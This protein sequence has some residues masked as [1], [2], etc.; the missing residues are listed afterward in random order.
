MLGSMSH[1]VK[2][3]LTSLDGGI[4]RLESGLKKGDGER[5]EAAARTLKSMIGR[6]RKMVLDILYYAKSRELETE[7]VDATRFLNDT[8]DVAAARAAAGKVEFV[9][10]I[11]D[12]LGTIRADTAA[13]SAALVNFLE[14]GVDACEG[15]KDGRLA[16][17]AKRTR[18]GLVITI[19]DNGSGMDRETR[20]KIFTLF[21]SSKGKR[22]TGIGL[23]ISN[24]TIEQ[25]GGS[26]R[27]ESA[28][29]EGSTF[30]ISLPD[31]A[32]Q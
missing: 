3:M 14:N 25:H 10:D 11:P 17:S 19:S 12:D 22:G 9:R 26:I 24:Q 4:Y 31:R 6:V 23:F 16:L 30:V 8:A 1:G 20:D 5:V 15:R 32:G 18:T 2:G 27:V 29:H 21:F 13:L 28:P 7:A